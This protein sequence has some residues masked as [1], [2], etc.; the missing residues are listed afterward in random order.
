MSSRF[1]I[2][3]RGLQDIQEIVEYIAWDNPL[4]ALALEADFYKA[5]DL[6]ANNPLAGFEKP[7]WTVKHYR[8]WAV[9]K[10]YV[11]AYLHDSRPLQIVRVL[12]AFQDITARLK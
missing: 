1:T 4:A 8:F 7:E 5:F 6:L 11:V 2:T 12:N 3:A 10:R 9:R